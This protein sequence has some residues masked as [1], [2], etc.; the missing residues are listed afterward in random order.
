MFATHAAVALVGAEREQQLREALARRDV[1][2]QA[3]GIVMERFGLAPDRA[4]GVLVRLSQ[5]ANRR[6]HEI[7]AE[8][9]ETR[10]LPRPEGG[11]VGTVPR[12]SSAP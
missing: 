7:A 3:M 1:I 4:F 10:T 6:L 9:V 11:A 2:G 12:P 5:H 8:V